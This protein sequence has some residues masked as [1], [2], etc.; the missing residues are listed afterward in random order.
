V[1]GSVGSHETGKS[2]EWEPLSGIQGKRVGMA[3]KSIAGT[4]QNSR[5]LEA[6]HGKAKTRSVL[7]LSDGG[8]PLVSNTHGLQNGE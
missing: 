1:Q 3:T 7:C 8:Q 6:V 5:P 4:G 2:S